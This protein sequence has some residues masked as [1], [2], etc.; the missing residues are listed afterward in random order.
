LFPEEIDST[1]KNLKPF[2]VSHFGQNRT[3]KGGKK[4]FIKRGQIREENQNPRKENKRKGKAGKLGT[5]HET[6]PKKRG[7]GK[8]RG[9][10]L[11]EEWRAGEL[12]GGGETQYRG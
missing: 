5:G 11:G 4:K 1:T 2:F 7:L 12:V 8:K 3:G 10:F 9:G 6:A